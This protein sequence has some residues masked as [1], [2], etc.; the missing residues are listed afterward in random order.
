[1]STLVPGP[2]DVAG[3]GFMAAQALI[4]HVEA[5]ISTSREHVENPE[6]L[7][8]FLDDAS[9][10]LAR[11][12]ATGNRA[13]MDRCAHLGQY[14][15]ATLPPS[16]LTG[17]APAPPL[18]MGVG[19]AHA[20]LAPEAAPPAG[21][22]TMQSNQM[23]SP[24]HMEIVGRLKS[25]DHDHGFGFVTPYC[26]GQEIFVPAWAFAGS[27]VPSPGMAVRLRATQ[28]ASL[29]MFFHTD[30]RAVR[31]MPEVVAP[32]TAP[33]GAAPPTADLDD[34][35]EISDAEYLAACLQVETVGA[36]TDIEGESDEMSDS[37]LLAA[38]AQVEEHP[39]A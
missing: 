9:V 19:G 39:S 12:G 11:M 3:S 30:F 31:W 37:D 32:P 7:L 23:D 25:W 13:A 28:D 10:L 2:G 29:L 8:D 26:G 14:L 24:M 22:A 1:M 18:A 35:D 27:V 5:T 21:H 34:D 20:A 38:C 15:R 6:Q 17:V 16:C 36:A 33:V 4:A